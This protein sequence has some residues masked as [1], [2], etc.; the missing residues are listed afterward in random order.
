MIERIVRGALGALVDGRK[1][2]VG[3]PE[4][5]SRVLGPALTYGGEPLVFLGTD[6]HETRAV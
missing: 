4:D 5:C 6:E 1:L 2:S 3:V